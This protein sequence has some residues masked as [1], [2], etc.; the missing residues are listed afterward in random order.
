MILREF[1]EYLR[2]PQTTFSSI[3]SKLEQLGLLR[4]VINPRDMRSF[5]LRLT[6]AGKKI[7]EAHR[8]NDFKQA[9][10][11]LLGL[12]EGEREEFVRIFQKAVN[13]MAAGGQAGD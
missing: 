9:R 10:E 7:V 12:D 8:E 11:V 3:V 5:S 2:V 13:R 6:G 4:R 1:R